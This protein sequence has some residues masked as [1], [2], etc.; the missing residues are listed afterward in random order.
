M[1]LWFIDRLIRYYKS[2]KVFPV[3][4]IQVLNNG[5]TTQ[6]SLQPSGFSFKAG[7]YAF[8][9]IPSITPLE[10]HPFTISSAPGE[11][12]LTFHI[13]NM[14]K[15]TW[16]ARLARIYGGE[17]S[18]FAAITALPIVN[19]DGPY[20]NPPDF[21]AHQ[22]IV[23][24][25]GGI[26]ITPMISILKDLQQLHKQ[27][28]VKLGH[29]KNVYLMWVVRDLAILDMFREVFDDITNDHSCKDVFHIMLRVTQRSFSAKAVVDSP[30]PFNPPPV[31][32]R[33]NIQ[34]EFS[35]IAAVCGTN[36]LAMVCGPA[37][38]VKEVQTAAYT[39]KFDLH[40]ETFEL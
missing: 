23:L 33:P 2:S 11:T 28:E 20:G 10:W 17:G 18:S 25:A 24:I 12:A 29:L 16:T 36:V 1:I 13:K 34:Q 32:G 15:N 8:I 38:M 22:N 21:A 5:D 3:V 27:N 19:V 4:D 6:I 30:P 39:F 9:N 31:M 35:D 40:M 7:Q 37:P 26:G 14:G